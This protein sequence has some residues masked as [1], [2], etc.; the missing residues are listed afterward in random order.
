VHDLDAPVDNITNL[1][2][3]P[4]PTMK[5][6]NIAR[7]DI[8]SAQHDR[9]Q[10][11]PRMRRNVCIVICVVLIT[12]ASAV[13]A[14]YHAFST[15]AEYDD[16]GL[17]MT[18]ISR[19]VNGQ[20]LY[21]EVQNIYGPF[22]FLYEYSAHVITGVSVSHDSIRFL[23]MSSWIASGV[24]LLLLVYRATV[25]LLLATAAHFLG[26]RTI[27]YVNGPEVAHPQ[28]LCILLLLGLALAVCYVDNRALLMASLGTFVGAMVLTK[29]NL[30]V[31]VAVA[32]VVVL[33]CGW[34]PARWHGAACM[35][36]SM[37][38]IVLPVVLMSGHIGEGWAMK[39][40]AVETISIAAVILVIFRMK[41][42]IG[43]SFRHLV[44]AGLCFLGT[45]AVICS[46]FLAHGSS[47][48]A[49]IDSVIL[50]PRSTF[51][52]GWFLA[53]RF[54]DLA[55]AWSVV[56]LAVAYYTRTRRASEKMLT[57]LKFSFAVGVALL[58]AKFGDSSRPHW[59]IAA[60]F[61]DALISF[62]IPFLWLVVVSPSGTNKLSGFSRAMLALVTVIQ[63]LYAYPVAGTQVQFSAILIIA[64][65][66]I[67]FADSLPFIVARLPRWRT[68]DVL[69]AIR[70]GLTLLL[71]GVYSLY[72]WTAFRRY[73][74]FEPVNLPG[75]HRL[76]LETSRAAVLR[77][78]VMRTNASCR[79][80]IT[81]PGMLSFYFWTALPVPSP[82]DYQT[83][84]ADLSD[85][86][87]NALVEDLSGVPQVCVIYNQDLIDKWTRGKDISS[88]PMMRFIESSF[89]KTFESGGYRF[90]IRP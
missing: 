8:T 47:L 41:F 49:M 18:L 74:N 5:T 56:G 24:L 54:T 17:F 88:K 59:R 85:A 34:R 20:P 69:L 32:A 7:N 35:A 75:A 1:A 66:S 43:L 48:H 82:M 81:A 58:S 44:F 19:V 63:V 76:H 29:I 11:T 13:R 12:C 6:A 46:F 89:R 45:V 30:G 83:W 25:S 62:A 60:T 15:F 64:V 39:Y 79:T 84:I 70:A 65:A 37:G 68:P 50:R 28:E 67:C 55:V 23:A 72:A 26:L 16:E 53:A 14:Y 71:A 73:E 4:Q 90:M 38:A 87:Q 21:D 3:I 52:Q 22:Y 78:S 42:D 27:L 86:E 61:E 77:E 33:V 2:S 36:V 31:I 51:G 57:L 9:A 10:L 40:C 80:P